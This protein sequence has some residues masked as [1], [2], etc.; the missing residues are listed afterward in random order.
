[1]TAVTFACRFACSMIERS[2]AANLSARSA[3]QLEK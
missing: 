2:Q 3:Q 1:M